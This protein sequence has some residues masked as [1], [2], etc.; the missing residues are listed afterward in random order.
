MS[1]SVR[2]GAIIRELRRHK[3]LTQEDLAEKT[4]R[5][6]DAI[7]QIERGVN[8]P[9]VE[10]LLRIAQAF[11]VPP[12]ALLA[13]ATRISD[14]RQKALA[15]AVAALY[16]LSDRDLDIAVV[17]LQAFPSADRERP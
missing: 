2:I 3:R 10:T 5:S 9:N 14:R 12:E 13:G 16:Q 15:L 6:V 4:N 7:S 8:S 11:E 17:Q 1:E